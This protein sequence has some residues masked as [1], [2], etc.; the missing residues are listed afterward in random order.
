MTERATGGLGASTHVYEYLR[1]EFMADPMTKE[2]L[3]DF[4]RTSRTLDAFWPWIKNKAGSYADRCRSITEAFGPLADYL[5]GAAQSAIHWR[6]S[7]DRNY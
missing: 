5:E 3:P 4:V 1:R 6:K 2:L 7:D